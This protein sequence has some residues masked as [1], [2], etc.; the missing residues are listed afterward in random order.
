MAAPSDIRGHLGHRHCHPVLGTGRLPRLHAPATAVLAAV[1]DFAVVLRGTD[2]GRQNV[3][4]SQ[5]MDLSRCKGL[6]AAGGSQLWRALKQP[7]LLPI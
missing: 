3:A 5:E 6:F 1:G 7:E 2:A 4:P